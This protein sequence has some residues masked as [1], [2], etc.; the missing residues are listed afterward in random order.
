M[1]ERRSVR[2]NN[3]ELVYLTTTVRGWTVKYQPGV[4]QHHPTLGDLL[5]A[6]LAEIERLLP[7][8]ITNTMKEVIIYI[9]ISYRYPS[10]HLN[11]LGACCHQSSDWLTEVHSSLQ[12]LEKI[13]QRNKIKS[14]SRMETWPRKKV[15]LRYTMLRVTWTGWKI[16]YYLELAGWLCPPLYN[17]TAEYHST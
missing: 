15:T 7:G 10:H 12:T 13:N 16:R 3:T 11:I 5:Q 17:S 4:W 6:D 2:Y 14:F 9:N 8:Q 1:I